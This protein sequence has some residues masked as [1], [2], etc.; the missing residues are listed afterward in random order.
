MKT[1]TPTVSTAFN[2]IF[3][4][5][6]LLAAWAALLAVPA[7]QAST[8]VDQVEDDLSDVRLLVP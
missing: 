1:N 2:R 3:F 7:A 8:I 5:G 6:P 4:V